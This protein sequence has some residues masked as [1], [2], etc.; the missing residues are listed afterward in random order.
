MVFVRKS[1]KIDEKEITSLYRL[2]GPALERKEV[3]DRE[4]EAIIKGEDQRILLVIGPC[5][6]DNEE[7][8]RKWRLR[9]KNSIC[10]TRVTFALYTKRTKQAKFLVMSKQR[11]MK[12]FIVMLV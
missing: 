2:E 6:S 1:N 10:Q 3:R 4:L 9:S 5:S 7:A 12:V 8:V 11:F